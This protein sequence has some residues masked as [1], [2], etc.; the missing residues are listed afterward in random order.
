MVDSIAHGRFVAEF[1]LVVKV[2]ITE[3]PQRICIKSSNQDRPSRTN[4]FNTSSTKFFE[5]ELFHIAYHG[6][7]AHSNAQG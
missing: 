3:D 6:Y 2:S 1:A 5:V 4:T 7:R